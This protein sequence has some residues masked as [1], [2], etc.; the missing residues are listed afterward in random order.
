MIKKWYFVLFIILTIILIGCEEDI[1]G[2]AFNEQVDVKIQ[3]YRDELNEN[4]EFDPCATEELYPLESEEIVKLI[5]D[6]Q[7]V[8]DRMSLK[9]SSNLITAGIVF[10][11]DEI[12]QI[13]IIFHN[14]YRDNEEYP[15]LSFCD[16][17]SGTPTYRKSY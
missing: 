11:D 8:R 9:K 1:I 2:E 14:V 7:K 5:Q 17:V 3:Y 6:R 16:Y 10:E 13:P 4:I 12:I 15:R